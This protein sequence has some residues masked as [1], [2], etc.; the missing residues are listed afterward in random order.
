MSTA[1]VLA[2]GDHSALAHFQHD[3][4]SEDATLTTPFTVAHIGLDLDSVRF[5]QLDD[6]RTMRRVVIGHVN[7]WGN[8]VG[9]GS[10][11][12]DSASFS[13]DPDQ[14]QPA[15]DELTQRFPGVTFTVTPAPVAVDD[16]SLKATAFRW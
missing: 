6:G 16:G 11:L 2:T 13:D 8:P 1:Y 5:T 4:A 7:Q 12:V 3:V 14:P 10:V 15:V 9:V